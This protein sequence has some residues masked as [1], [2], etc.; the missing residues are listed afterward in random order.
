MKLRLF[1]IGLYTL[2]YFAT[3]IPE[4]EIRQQFLPLVSK[5]WNLGNACYIKMVINNQIFDGSRPLE[6]RWDQ[7]KKAI[8]F[9]NK[10]VLD[11]GCFKG[12]FSILSVKEGAK[13]A[14]G[15]DFIADFIVAAGMLAQAFEAGNT[16]FT[17]LNFDR[18]P[19][20][21]ILGTDYDLV[22]CMS[23]LNWVGDK[24]RFLTYLSHLPCIIFEGH[25]ADAIEI[26]RFTDA[27]FKKYS[28][29]GKTDAGRTLIFF[30]K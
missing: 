28:I 6:A 20:E 8:D 13:I 14:V 3:T 24:K 17:C 10:K 23:I 5:A 4:F 26:K 30:E 18:D 16:H 7:I 19:Y 1:G 21:T 9:K 12:I 15:A 11:L 25:E 27:G 29:L 2:G 22:F